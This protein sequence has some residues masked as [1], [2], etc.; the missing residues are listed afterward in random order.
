MCTEG[1]G[2]KSKKYSKF[3]VKIITKHERDIDGG[4]CIKRKLREIAFCEKGK[5]KMF[6]ERGYGKNLLTKR[7]FAATSRPK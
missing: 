1:F 2:S 6:M 4:K 5:Q 7:M 3:V